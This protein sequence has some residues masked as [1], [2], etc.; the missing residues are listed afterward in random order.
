[1]DELI[2]SLIDRGVLKTPWI[3]D[4]FSKVDRVDFV[5]ERLRNLTYEDGALPIGHGQTISQPYTVAFMLELLEP[6][7]G[8]HILDIGSGSGWQSALLAEIVGDSGRIY[9]VEIN[10]NIFKIGKR[11]LT[12]YPDLSRRIELYCQNA[13]NGLPKI[14]KEI[15]DFDNIIAAAEVEEVPSGWREQLKIGGKLV[16][17]RDNSVFLEIK[18]TKTDFEINQFPGFVFVPFINLSC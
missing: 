11:N 16:Y 13:N 18:K 15:G 1:M 7:K 9:S 2:K 3:I 17:P 14:A 12:K 4:A 5:P 10:P 6:Q 8:G